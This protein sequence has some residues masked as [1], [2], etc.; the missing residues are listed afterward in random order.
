MMKKISVIIPIYN[1]GNYLRDCLDSIL[2]QTLDDIEILC[3]D[4]ASTDPTGSILSEYQKRDSRILI[5]T[6]QQNQGAGISRNIGLNMAKGKYVIFLDGDDVFEPDMLQETYQR[7]ETYKADVCVFREDQFYE[8]IQEHMSYPYSRSISKSL[9]E[10]GA[11]GP[12][13]IKDIIFNLWNGWA[14]DKLFLRKFI[15]DNKLSFQEMRSSEDGFFVHAA[16]AI[17]KRITFLNK[18][19]VHHRINRSSSLSNSRDS[20]W[21]CC[22]IYLQGLRK[23][24]IDKKLFSCFEKSFMNWAADFLYWNYWSLNEKSRKKMFLSLKQYMLGGLGLLHYGKNE[25]YNDFYYWF[26]R[27]IDRSD[28]YLECRVP[29][30]DKDR[31]ELLFQHN[32]KKIDKVFQYLKVHQCEAAVWGAGIRGNAFV[33]RYGS[34]I[35]KVYDR[36]ERKAGKEIKKGCRIEAFNAFTCKGIGFIIVTN[37]GYVE[38]IAK[39][40]KNIAPDIKVF[41]LEQYLLPHRSLPLCFGNCL[42]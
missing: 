37:T 20:S 38:S 7:A 32:E 28:T 8:S 34:H 22:Y 17:S 23:Y 9:E 33:I 6:N 29:T 27:E 42:F 41:D 12:E 14:W 13:R 30:D 40:V 15:L 21:E 1:G 11:F 4:D 25:F 26:I 18:V 24:L 19:Y 2:M 36:D 39:E 16:L 3:I 5:V 35:T 10:Q 31:W